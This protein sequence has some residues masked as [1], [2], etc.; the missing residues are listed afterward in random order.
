MKTIYLDYEID[1]TLAVD[2]FEES[3]KDYKIAEVTKLI[4]DGLEV[5]SLDNLVEA[6]ATHIFREC[7]IDEKN[8]NYDKNGKSEI[9]YGNLKV[10]ITF[11]STL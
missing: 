4:A 11:I 5:D 2:T 10:V 6:V 3:Q 8:K 1:G 7:R 9:K